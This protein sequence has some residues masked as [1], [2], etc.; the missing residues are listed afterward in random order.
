MNKP[1]KTL[2]RLIA[3]VSAFP[4]IAVEPSEVQTGDV[5]GTIGGEIV[6]ITGAQKTVVTPGAQE[7]Y[8]RKYNNMYNLVYNFLSKNKWNIMCGLISIAS[9]YVLIYKVIPEINL[10][11][12][13]KT[14]DQVF[15]AKIN[16]LSEKLGEVKNLRS[17]LSS[18][19]S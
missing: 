11:K 17:S 18:E 1:F 19:Q 16:I 8:N 15:A 13:L 6:Q 9:L 2:S 12:Q 3:I 14:E 10:V 5:V 4:V 7:E